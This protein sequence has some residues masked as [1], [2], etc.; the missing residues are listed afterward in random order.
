MDSFQRTT[1]RANPN[2]LKT[3]ASGG[4]WE[5]ERQDQKQGRDPWGGWSP[6]RSHTGFVNGSR[7]IRKPSRQLRHKPRAAGLRVGTPNSRP[8]HGCEGELSVRLSET[9]SK[10]EIIFKSSSLRTDQQEGE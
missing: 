8:S 5:R 6:F 9:C 1:A 10:E 2:L 4:G 7:R 3:A